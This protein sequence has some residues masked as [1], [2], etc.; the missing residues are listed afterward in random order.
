MWIRPASNLQK[1]V[2]GD[3]S[4][5]RLVPLNLLLSFLL[6]PIAAYK[7]IIWSLNINYNCLTDGSGFS[8]LA[9]HIN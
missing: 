9:V 5:S 4:L 3:F 1:S 2:A 8:W 6:V 7:I